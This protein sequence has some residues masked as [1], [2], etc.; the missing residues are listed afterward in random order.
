MKSLLRN[1]FGRHLR[2]FYPSPGKIYLLREMRRFLASHTNVP[3]A[4][5]VAAADF[6]YRYLFD[7]RTYIGVDQDARLVKLGKERYPGA[8]SIGIACDLFALER[9]APIADVVVSTHTIAHVE[10]AR[11]TDGAMLL[12]SLV[13]PGGGMFF[14]IPHP[15]QEEIEA[16]LRATFSHVT[17]INY[18]ARYSMAIEDYFATR[19]GSQSMFKV[20]VLAIGFGISW[21]LSYLE[22]VIR[23]ADPAYSLYICH[24]KVEGELPTRPYLSGMFAG[25]ADEVILF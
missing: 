21:M 8:D 25:S 1:V 20:L 9:L 15:H 19:T 12:A 23:S 10:R 4:L 11:W 6:K 2:S 13:K 18:G 17:R 16:N 22:S 7:V 5:D 24:Y 3:V 14:N